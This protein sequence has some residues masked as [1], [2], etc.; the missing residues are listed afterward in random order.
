[1]FAVIEYQQR[2]ARAQLTHDLSDN[3]GGAQGET[4]SGGDHQGNHQGIFAD[5]EIQEPRPVRKLGLQSTPDQERQGRL[6]DASGPNH[7]DEALG[8]Q[9]TANGRCLRVPPDNSDLTRR[10]A[11]ADLSGSRRRRHTWSLGVLGG[12]RSPWR[13]C[14]SRRVLRDRRLPDRSYKAVASPLDVND[15]SG[16]PLAIAQHPAQTGDVKTQTPFRHCDIGPDRGDQLPLVDDLPPSLE[17]GKKYVQ[18][19]VA[20]WNRN[21]VSLKQTFFWENAIRPKYDAVRGQHWRFHSY[22]V[23]AYC[24]L[25]QHSDIQPTLLTSCQSRLTEHFGARMRPWRGARSSRLMFAGKCSCAV[26]PSP[27]VRNRQLGGDRTVS[28]A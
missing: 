7:R 22:Y 11:R 3:L 10:K 18:S 1:M 26:E 21:S 24:G 6:A 16:A 9:A 15:I 14:S 2:I 5:A 25:L 20:D 12:L 28:S 23:S 19:A 13:D 27:G 8:Y 4:D 17:Q